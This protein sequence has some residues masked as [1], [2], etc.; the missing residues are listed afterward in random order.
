[1]KIL[2]LG[3]TGF[4]GPHIVDA[5]LKGKHTLTLFNRGKTNP[6]LFPDLEKL[7]GDR[8]KGDL[9][10][11]EGRKWD[12]V[13]DTHGFF[14]RKIK[15]V[16]QILAPNIGQ[17][18]FIST[19]SVYPDDSQAPI[20]EQSPVGKMADPTVE[21]FGKNFENYGPGKALCEQAAE[22][23]MPGHVT[24]LRPGLIVGPGDT[25]DRYTYWP[26]RV[27]RGGEV[28]APGDPDSPVQY[29]DAR[30]LAD[31]SVKTI[32]DGHAGTY[33]VV[34]PPGRQ[35]IRELLIGCKAVSGSDARFT[36]VDEAFLTEQQVSSWSDM[37]VWTG[38]DG[39]AMA[40]V[41]NDRAT[42][43][44][45]SFRPPAVT[46]KDTLDWAKTRGAEYKV[47]AG[48]APEKEAK[49]LAAWHER[50]AK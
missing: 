12:A 33:N 40:T 16:L 36:W 1:M 5:A 14:P 7:R 50:A 18:V 47:R 20:D 39:V 2:I 41:R 17:Y 21:E 27:D 26:L 24:S 35:T 4:I 8:D 38:K 3:G 22:E 45:L 10:S 44:G 19:I 37:P 29:I 15:E 13:V 48:I 46:I 34:I 49:V 28:L 25:S 43:I 31:F 6:Q 42:A 30:D 23:K 9:K 11:L 32:E